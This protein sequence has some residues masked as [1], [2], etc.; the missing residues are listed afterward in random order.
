MI[1]VCS[2]ILHIKQYIFYKCKGKVIPHIYYSPCHED[3]LG[4]LP[5]IYKHHVVLKFKSV[6]THTEHSQLEI[7]HMGICNNVSCQKYPILSGGYL[8]ER[9]V[10]LLHETSVLISEQSLSDCISFLLNV[11][12]NDFLTLNKVINPNVSSCRKIYI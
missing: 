8:T 11:T 3:V 10:H 5:Y 4:S 1:H 7:M 12:H 6:I 9:K 2:T